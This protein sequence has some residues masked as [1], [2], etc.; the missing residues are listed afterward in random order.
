M[1]INLVYRFAIKD[2]SHQ[3]IEKSL[4]I[5]VQDNDDYKEAPKFK[6]TSRYRAGA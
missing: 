1:V 2:G 6:K 3:R 4:E 5:I